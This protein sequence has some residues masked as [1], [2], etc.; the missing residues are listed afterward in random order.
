MEIACRKGEECM[1]LNAAY[2][3]TA[4][5]L[6][7]AGIVIMGCAFVY[8]GSHS[9]G[10]TWSDSFEQFDSIDLKA[11]FCTVNVEPIDADEECR[12]DFVNMPKDTEA[13]IEDDTLVI[14]D[15]SDDRKNFR[16]VSFGD[17]GWEQGEVT[18]YLPEKDYKKIKLSMGVVSDSVIDGITCDSMILD[19]GVGNLELRNSAVAK[20][21][22]ID[23]GTG[24]YT[25]RDVTVK[26]KSDIDIGVG[27]FRVD[28]VHMMQKCDLDIGTGDCDI[29]GCEFA[30]LALD[31]GVGDLK[32]LSTRLSGDVDITL[33]TGDI[34]IELLGD[35]MHYNFR[36]DAG[37]GDT[38]IDGDNIKVMNNF[39]AKY[40]FRADSGVG[41]IDIT[42]S[43]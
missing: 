30:E 4:G 28:T 25:M 3:V 7:V 31:G 29:T 13:Y 19:A 9:E 27:T 37:V 2:W 41:D 21:L 12:I 18:I 36:V 5:V 6:A 42:F 22:D 32:F 38:T 20:D 33:G 16:F 8:H 34:E 23:C 35:P 1:K 39:D 24:D 26:G 40:E 43:K 10:K 17:F 11:G 15:N 14:D